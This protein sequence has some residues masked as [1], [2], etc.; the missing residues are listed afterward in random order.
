MFAKSDTSHVLNIP[1]QQL[2]IW[3][4][5]GIWSKQKKKYNM[6][7]SFTLVRSIF[8]CSLTVYETQRK[9]PTASP[10]RKSIKVERSHVKFPFFSSSF[11]T[12]LR[13]C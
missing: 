8:I 9:S 6:Y 13:S 5:S 7:F 2:Y 4:P 3:T 10:I 11:V 12:K 1:V